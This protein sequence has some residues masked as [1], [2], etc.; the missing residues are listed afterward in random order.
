MDD[1]FDTSFRSALNFLPGES[2]VVYAS[3]VVVSLT[4]VVYT[5]VV[6]VSNSTLHLL[7]PLK[8]VSQGSRLGQSLYKTQYGCGDLNE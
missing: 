1:S 7:S 3:D 8:H 5:S 4:V 2:V 6:V